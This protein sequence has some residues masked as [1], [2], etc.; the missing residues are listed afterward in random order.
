MTDALQVLRDR[1]FLVSALTREV[2]E[3]ENES[4]LQSIGRLLSSVTN[5]S[6]PWASTAAAVAPGVVDNIL[7]EEGEPR[8]I[9]QLWPALDAP[10]ATVQVWVTNGRHGPTGPSRQRFVT[11]TENVKMPPSFGLWTSSHL[12]KDKSMWTVYLS[13]YLGS[14][15]YPSPWHVWKLRVKPRSSIYQVSN[16]ADWVR[17]VERF[18]R[19]VHGTLR[20]DWP[21]VSEVY[22][23]VHYTLNGVIAVQGVAFQSDFGPTTPIFLDVESTFWLQWS[24]T[25]A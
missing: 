6:S 8:R 19:S 14:S 17:L 24:F 13:D 7:K 16:A 11:P 3:F 2:E 9:A 10:G 12:G 1:A 18:P 21:G 4:A 22:D 5:T 20:P 15:L 25:N 23:G